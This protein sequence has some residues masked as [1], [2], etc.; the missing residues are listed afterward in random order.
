MQKNGECWGGVQGC[1]PIYLP[2]DNLMHDAHV[3]SLQGGVGLTMTLI[4]QEYWVPHLR[5]HPRLVCELTEQ[6]DLSHL[7]CWV[8]I[9]QAQ[10]HIR[11]KKKPKREGKAYILLHA[12]WV[13]TE[14]NSQGVYQ[15]S[16]TIYSM[17]GVA[18]EHR[19]I[20][21]GETTAG[22]TSVFAG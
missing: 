3:L 12:L 18:C 5:T 9:L 14:P 16:Q 15:K 10:L 13:A 20:S 8:W 2:P 21:G 22:N 17:E 11:R 1:Y 7:N 19:R 6:W 4:D